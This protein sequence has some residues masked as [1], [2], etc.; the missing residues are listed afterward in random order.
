M[1]KL[2]LSFYGLKEITGE[3]D[4]P[5]IVNWFKELGASWVKDDETAWC[6]CFM[7]WCAM[8]CG[9]E[10]PQLITKYFLSARSWLKVGKELD[11]PEL[12][13]VVV[14]WR[15][16]RTSWKGHVGLYISEDDDHIYTLGGN[17]NNSVC[18]KA[19]PK[20]RLLSYRQLGEAA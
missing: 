15:E 20:Y 2:A 16:D 13:C 4:H 1:L 19:Y 14:F 12:G 10:W 5:I 6:S 3:A 17:Q 8:R 18:I 9:L 7:N 11:K